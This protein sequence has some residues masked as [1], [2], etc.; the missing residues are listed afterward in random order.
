MGHLL[1]R[2]QD[3]AYRDLCIR[4]ARRHCVY[5]QIYALENDPHKALKVLEAGGRVVGFST[6]DKDLLAAIGCT[7]VVG[8]E[9]DAEDNPDFP[10]VKGYI[11]VYHND[12]SFYSTS[13][14][15]LH[16]G[17]PVLYSVSGVVGVKESLKKGELWLLPSITYSSFRDRNKKRFMNEVFPDNQ[18]NSTQHVDRGEICH[19]DWDQY[20]LSPAALQE[21]KESGF[22]LSTILPAAV[23]C[24]Q[25]VDPVLYRTLKNFARNPSSSGSLLVKN[26][27][28]GVLPST[29][30]LPSEPSDKDFTSELSLLTV[31]SILGHP[32]GYKPE[33]GGRLVQNIVPTKASQTEQTSTSSKTNLYFHTE[34]AFHPYR[35]KWLALLCLKGDSSAHTTICNVYDIVHALPEDIC[36]ALSFPEFVTG[37]DISYTYSNSTSLSAPHRVLEGTPN[38][39]RILWDWSLTQGLTDRARQALLVL[40]DAVRA[41]QSYVVLEPGDMLL[42][43]NTILVH[44]RS[45]FKPRFDGTDRWLQRTFVLADTNIPYDAFTQDAIALEFV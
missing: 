44:G 21:T 25:G 17:T 30:A 37:V 22:S 38:K 19:P 5:M 7:I 8:D 12:V 34:A 1:S 24:G 33:M 13:A 9:S 43:D 16:G 39:P 29:P 18:T 15:I 42:I 26:C 10:H 32:T 6:Q 2:I 41:V 45:P 14:R 23:L 20:P 27:P 31:T 4:R 11:K 36:D 28:V 3:N 35:P 40:K